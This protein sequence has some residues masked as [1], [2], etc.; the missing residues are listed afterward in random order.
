MSQ[1][2]L[3]KALR[4]F[5]SQKR[6]AGA[7]LVYSPSVKMASREVVDACIDPPFHFDV[8]ARLRP[9][10]TL[11]RARR[12]RRRRL[13]PHSRPSLRGSPFI[14]CPLPAAPVI[15]ARC[16]SSNRVQRNRKADVPVG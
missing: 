4:S 13:G 6:G 14:P 5:R 9:R 3:I 8:S 16:P 2:D 10:Q 7:E 1:E 15:R 11:R 12:T